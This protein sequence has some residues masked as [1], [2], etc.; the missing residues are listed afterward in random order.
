M[1]ILPKHVCVCVF[2]CV[3]IYIVRYTLYIKH[4]MSHYAT[5]EVT[6]SLLGEEDL[7]GG[8]LGGWK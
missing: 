6:M 8:W 1:I 7:G 3:Y 4:S 5:G 2:L